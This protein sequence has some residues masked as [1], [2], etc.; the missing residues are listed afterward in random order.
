MSGECHKKADLP[1]IPRK[2]TAHRGRKHPGGRFTFRTPRPGPYFSAPAVRPAWTC[3][4][5]TAYTT[6]TGSIAIIIPAISAPQ[7]FS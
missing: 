4:W 1:G 6:S 2:E 7:S 3:R 5:K